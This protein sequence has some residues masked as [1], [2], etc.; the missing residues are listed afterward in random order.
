[1]CDLTSEDL[2]SH[3]PSVTDFITNSLSPPGVTS[4]LVHCFHGRSRSAAV[5]MAYLMQKHK[6]SV[7]KSF[8]ILKS[9]RK[10]VNPNPGFMAQLR[11]WE[12]MRFKLE[13][14]FLRYKMYKLQTVSE[15]LRRSK[16]ISK[17]VV[18]SIVEPDPAEQGKHTRQCWMIYKCK[19]C[20]RVV[21][22]CDN[23]IP[24]QPGQ[25]P[26][27]WC[28]GGRAG[29]S[30]CTKTVS[31]TPMSWMEAALHCGLSGPLFCPQCRLESLSQSKCY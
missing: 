9:K 16:I 24:H 8:E 31:I 23:L 20:R 11:L 18:K 22:T 10:C 4:V 7:E 15:H 28:G 26:T 21:A 13:Q 19:A 25:G 1:M 27:W 6:Y 14:D 3:L 29:E 17:D 30:C 12:A 2:L 5:V